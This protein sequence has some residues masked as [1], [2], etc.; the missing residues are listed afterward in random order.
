MNILDPATVK[1]G[2]GSRE[3]A[4]LLSEISGNS[5]PDCSSQ[6]TNCAMSALYELYKG[7]SKIYKKYA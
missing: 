3:K 6:V 1:K 4:T 2:V 7:L 5:A